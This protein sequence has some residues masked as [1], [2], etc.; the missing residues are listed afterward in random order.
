[1][2]RRVFISLAKPCQTNAR[3]KV[4]ELDSYDSSNQAK[5]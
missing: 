3:A 1:L 2:M 5:L 4:K